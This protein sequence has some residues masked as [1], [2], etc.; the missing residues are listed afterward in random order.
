MKCPYE[1]PVARE[2]I[3]QLESNEFTESSFGSASSPPSTPPTSNSLETTDD[4]LRIDKCILQYELERETN[5]ATDEDATHTTEELVKHLK[6]TNDKLLLKAQ[7]YKRKCEKY[8][9]TIDEMRVEKK[10]EV[11]SLK[12]FYYNVLVGHSRSA[13]ILKKSLSE[14]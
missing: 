6:K 13:T 9:T 4:E 7:K 12:N 1:L 3:N 10:R 8:E 2:G 14:S 11:N 5:F